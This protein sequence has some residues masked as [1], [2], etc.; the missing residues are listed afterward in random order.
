MQ[1][2][3]YLTEEADAQ[4]RLGRL[5][6]ALKKYLSIITVCHGLNLSPFTN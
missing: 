3:L 1:S 2:L 5:G 6:P 4:N